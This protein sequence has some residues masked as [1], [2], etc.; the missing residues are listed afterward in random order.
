M[1]RRVG[2][3]KL[4]SSLNSLLFTIYPRTLK[5]FAIQLKPFSGMKE[6]NRKN[7][8]LRNK[9]V[10]S[11]YKTILLVTAFIISFFLVL[12]THFLL[13]YIQKA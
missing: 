6:L 2:V 7:Q 1:F 8:M 4:K 9:K 11:K 12:L 10:A 5:E 13:G 3:L